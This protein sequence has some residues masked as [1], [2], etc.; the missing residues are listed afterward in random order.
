M[1]IRVLPVADNPVVRCAGLVGATCSIAN[2]M[3]AGVHVG[4]SL[5]ARFTTI[6]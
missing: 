5:V 6:I 3:T 1:G 2:P 4:A